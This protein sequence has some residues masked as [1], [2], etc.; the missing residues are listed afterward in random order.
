M[1]TAF[2]MASALPG[3][4]EPLRAAT[5]VQ[6][7]GSRCPAPSTGIEEAAC[8]C[9]FEATAG[10]TRMTG[11]PHRPANQI[12]EAVECIRRPP[13][14]IHALVECID[15][16]PRGIHPP[17]GVHP[18]LSE[19]HSRTRGVHSW[20]SRRD[21]SVHGGVSMRSRGSFT[22]SWGAF[23]Y[24]RSPFMVFQ[25]RSIRSRRGSMRSRGSFYAFVG[26]IHVLAE[27]IH[28]H[29]ELLHAL[30]EC[31]HPKA[32]GTDAVV[33]LSATAS[34]APLCASCAS[35]KRCV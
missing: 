33:E 16:S 26:C 10:T 24:S 8:W 1:T 27:S 25:A 29:A 15:S 14:D 32:L 22:H 2:W 13:D 23:P 30:P 35:K 5:E 11:C 31:I 17:R 7:A 9:V 12:H 20:P 34:A 18:G 21:P 3:P 6:H 4:R 19:R 28:A